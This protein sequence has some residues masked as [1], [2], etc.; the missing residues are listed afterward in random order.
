[1]S[2]STE[3]RENRHFAS[4]IKFLV[5]PDCAEEIRSWA[6]ARLSPDPNADGDSGDTYLTT[7]LY[8]DTKW[9]DVFHRKGSFG[10]SKYRIRRYGLGEGVF[11]ERKL[12]TRNLVSKRRTVVGVDE[13]NR[14]EDADPDERW[15]GYWF[16]RRLLAR[17]LK[18]VCQI[19][20][21]RTARVASTNAGTIRLTLD[22]DLRAIATDGLVFDH[23]RRG[24]LL[25][26]QNHILELKY[27]YAQPAVFQELVE[28]FQLKPQA[29]SKYRLAA[30]ALGFP[31][32]AGS[33]GAATAQ[34]QESK[35][36]TS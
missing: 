18:R 2:P 11:L 23:D 9:F 20:Y 28:E 4:E 19:S 24:T 13:L 25:S 32:E 22:Q 16:H 8:F 26:E 15:E 17:E 29:V 3:V 21:L 36:L 10:R 31:T 12:K 33:N 5:T 35:C 7:S 27:R 30:A 1:M 14:L 34:P 6:R